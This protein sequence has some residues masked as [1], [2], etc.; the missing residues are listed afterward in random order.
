MDI[1][2]RGVSKSFGTKQVLKNFSALFKSEERVWISGP[3]GCGKTTLLNLILG[4]QQPDEGQL[5]GTG[6]RMAA[7]FQED[8]LCEGVS[9]AVNVWLA[10]PS[11]TPKAEIEEALFRL[12]LAREDIYIPVSQLSGGMRRRVAIARAIMAKA[13]VL[14]MDEP[15]KGLDEKTKQTVLAEIANAAKG[16]LLLFV[17][18]D[19]ADANALSARRLWLTKEK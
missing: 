11:A 6:Q 15:L 5:L 14:V 9:A 8:R 19:E 16:K 17:S 1:E 4:L 3:S 10:C 13:Q 18:H 2:L 12:G 7:V